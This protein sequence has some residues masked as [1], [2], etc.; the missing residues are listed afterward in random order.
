MA[1]RK[2]SIGKL[3]KGEGGR[4]LVHM[5]NGDGSWYLGNP[6]EI[7]S[8]KLDDCEY[9]LFKYV[10]GDQYCHYVD[11]HKLQEDM[12]TVR[13]ACSQGDSAMARDT[14]RQYVPDTEKW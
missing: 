4:W 6:E 10:E 13:C 7:P 9:H 8:S 2:L 5:Q 3:E 11:L 14:V 1:K 12:E